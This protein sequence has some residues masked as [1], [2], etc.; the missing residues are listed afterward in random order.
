MKKIKPNEL[1]QFIVMRDT[2]NKVTAFFEKKDCTMIM[3]VWMC[4]R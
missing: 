4:A 1:K 3:H 2:T